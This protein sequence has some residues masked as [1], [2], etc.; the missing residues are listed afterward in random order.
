MAI[1]EKN[2]AVKECVAESNTCIDGYY[3]DKLTNTTKV[4]FNH[5]M[6]N[7]Q[8]NLHKYIDFTSSTGFLL[9]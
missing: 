1:L 4:Q 7:K 3:K 5:P 6:L 9:I 8:V 2:F